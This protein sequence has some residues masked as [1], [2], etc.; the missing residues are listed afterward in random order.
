MAGTIEIQGLNALRKILEAIA[1][2][3]DTS[4]LFINMGEYLKKSIKERT[5]EGVDVYGRDFIPYSASHA[6]RRAEKELPTDVVDLFFTGS[7]MAHMTYSHT[8]EELRVFFAPSIDESGASNPEKAYY[9]HQEREFF[10]MSAD[11][12]EEIQRIALEEI[13]RL[14]S[15]V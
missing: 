13:D 8:T 6:K 10:E 7:M 15:R 5:S 11:D 9:L 1:R 4:S 14:L 12:I 2:G 3:L